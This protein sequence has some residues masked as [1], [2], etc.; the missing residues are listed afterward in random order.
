MKKLS[1]LKLDFHLPFSDC[2]SPTAT[3]LNLESPDDQLYRLLESLPEIF[4]CSVI[5]NLACLVTEF[6]LVCSALL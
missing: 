6:S 3:L 4:L 1:A 2:H 5:E